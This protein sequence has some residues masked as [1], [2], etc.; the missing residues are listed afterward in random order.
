MLP[1]AVIVAY[2]PSLEISTFEYATLTDAMK[3]F[4][5][6]MADPQAVAVTLEGPDGKAIREYARED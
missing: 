1:Y 4:R 6:L 3:W 5:V 2:G